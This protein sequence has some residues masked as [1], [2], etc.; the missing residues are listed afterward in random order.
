[1]DMCVFVCVYVHVPMYIMYV[2]STYTLFHAC[3]G[4]I[5][6]FL[7]CEHTYTCTYILFVNTSK[8]LYGTGI[9]AICTEHSDSVVPFFTDVY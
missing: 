8:S 6:T 4:I 2:R 7:H 5:C 9:L 3:V 1:M